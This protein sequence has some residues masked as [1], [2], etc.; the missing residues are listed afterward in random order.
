M[1]GKTNK[2]QQI[3]A[4]AAPT[5]LHRRIAESLTGQVTNGQLKPGQKL[6]S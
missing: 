4:N 2:N 1:N 5:A 6:P 3:S